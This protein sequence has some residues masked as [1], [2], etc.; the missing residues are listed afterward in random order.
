MAVISSYNFFGLDIEV[1]KEVVPAVPHPRTQINLIRGGDWRILGGG[2]VVETGGAG[3]LLTAM[4]P[5]SDREWDFKAKDHMIASPAALKANCFAAQVPQADYMIVQDTSPAAVNHP[6]AEAHLPPG[7]ILIGGGARV[8]W[9]QTG[10]AGNLLYA[11]RPG[12]GE[13]WYAAAK[14]H[15]TPNPS[16]I[17]AF[18]IGLSESFL[19]SMRLRVVRIRAT[20]EVPVPHPA[21]TCGIHER[22][23]TLVS[24]GAE[25]HWGGA[26]SLLTASCP[27]T[28]GP[29][30]PSGLYIWEAKGKDHM[31]PDPSTIDVWC[32][33]LVPRG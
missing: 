10:G 11:S 29:N 20:S 24:G 23:G 1:H 14:D 6:T 15:V 30:P 19:S 28:I 16:T 17:T 4:Y 18:A 12:I 22:W 25:I 32:L 26:G 13:S 7:F 8:N 5:V 21:V 2:A 33:A 27:R 3:N 9:E 31:N